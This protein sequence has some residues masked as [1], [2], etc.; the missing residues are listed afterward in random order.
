MASTEFAT[1]SHKGAAFL[2][3]VGFALVAASAG[4]AFAPHY[5]WQVTKFAH[6]A[7]AL[8]FANGV[9]AVG[10]L[11]FFGLGIVAR[12]AGSAAP[13]VDSHGQTEAL[14][15]ELNLV[16][17]QLST[18][19]AQ[20][21]TSLMQIHESVTAVATQQQA[22]LQHQSAASQPGDHSQDAVFRLAASLDKLHAHFDERVHAVDLQLRAG[23]E[24]LL[25]V[26]H[27]LRRML[28]SAQPG[29]VGNSP[30]AAHAHH[31]SGQ[32]QTLE[33]G[34]DFY[35]TMQKLEAIAG[36]PAGHGLPGGRQPQAP[37]PSQ[38]HGEALDALL[39]EE[40]RDRY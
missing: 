24:T 20:L 36:D 8:G 28:G 35:E 30:S 25:N 29:P 10:G 26:S 19:I 11:F 6:Q 27:E 23:F 9:L 31:A 22:Q 17:E 18:K 12:V 2:F 14:Q 4:L 7:A 3:L 15:A 5:S 39:P 13:V 34:I 32:G 21:R 16:N 40:Y 37:F 1:R 38:G 33:G